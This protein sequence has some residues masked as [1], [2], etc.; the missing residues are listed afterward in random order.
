MT[1]TERR[2][3]LDGLTCLI[4]ELAAAGGV[5][6]LPLLLNRKGLPSFALITPGAYAYTVGGPDDFRHIA[7]LL[8]AFEAGDCGR[9]AVL[10]GV[11]PPGAS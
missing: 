7:D 9:A 5:D 3:W 1:E 10:M 4:V 8:G 11:P 2:R 6:D